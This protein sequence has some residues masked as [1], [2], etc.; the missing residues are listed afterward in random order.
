MIRKLSLLI[1]LIPVTCFVA[2]DQQ[3][4]SRAKD[5]VG[6]WYGEQTVRGMTVRWL[7]TRH[8]DGTFAA[9]FAACEEGKTQG[10]VKHFGEWEYKDETYHTTVTRVEN[11]DGE[12]KPKDPDKDYVQTYRVINLSD[13]AFDYVHT[14]NNVEYSVEKVDD[15]YEVSCGDSAED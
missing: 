12:E 3:N 6:T 7:N 15:S 4:T 2:C 14:G 8:A 13:S 1:N 5:L 11:A 10:T 9:R